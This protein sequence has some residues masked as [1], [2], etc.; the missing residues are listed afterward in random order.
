MNDGLLSVLQQ[1]LPLTRCANI[2]QP[3]RKNFSVTVIDFVTKFKVFI[4][5]DS[6]HICRKFLH[7]IWFYLNYI[8]FNLKL[9]FLSELVIY[10]CAVCYK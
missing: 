8:Y 6:G 7:D 9:Y 3:L 10:V 1:M 2:N 4:E 5:E